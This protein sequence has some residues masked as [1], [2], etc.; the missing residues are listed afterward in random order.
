MERRF[1]IIIPTLFKCVNILNDLLD[2]LNEDRFVSEIIL[3]DNTEEHIAYENLIR[4]NPKIKIYSENKN[5]YVNPSW[6]KGVSLAKEDYIGILNDDIL[7]PNNLFGIMT[8][9]NLESMGIIGA[10]HPFIAQVQEPKRF[11]IPN[12]TLWLT[13]HR[14]WGYGIFMVMKK[15]HYIHIPEDML[16]WCGDDYLFH[17]NIKFGRSNYALGSAIQTKMS[18]TSDD[19]VFD[20]I[21]NKDVEIYESK[22]KI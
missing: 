13:P 17:Q 16:I 4:T 2:T 1:S 5:L 6:N 22:Y 10:L 7:V 15:S 20:A 8:Q 11:Q 19:P 14:L 9:V 21:K 18:S 12:T 3:I